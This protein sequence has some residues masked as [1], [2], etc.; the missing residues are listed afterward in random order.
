MGAQ[1][2]IRAGGWRTAPQRIGDPTCR[3]APIHVDQQEGKQLALFV[4]AKL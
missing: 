1:R 2:D 3:D 4:P